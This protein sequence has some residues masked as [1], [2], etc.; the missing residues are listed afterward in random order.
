MGISIRLLPRPLEIRERIYEVEYLATGPIFGV[1]LTDRMIRIRCFH[2][3]LIW[4]GFILTVC[5]LGCLRSGDAGGL[6]YECWF[7]LNGNGEIAP[8]TVPAV[9]DEGNISPEVEDTAEEFF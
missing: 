5:G 2:C 4:L 3:L 6:R 9:L 8:G 7:E 1:H